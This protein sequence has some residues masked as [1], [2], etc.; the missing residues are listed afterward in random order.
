MK[1]PKAYKDCMCLTSNSKVSIKERPK[2]EDIKN[3]CNEIFTYAVESHSTVFSNSAIILN[4]E[5]V[6]GHISENKLKLR[7][8]ALNFLKKVSKH[9]KIII[10]INSQRIISTI[11]SLM[12]TKSILI[13]GIYYVEMGKNKELVY[14]NNIYKD[15]SISDPSISVIMISSLNLEIS[16]GDA[17]F[18]ASFRIKKKLNIS[19]CPIST[20]NIPITFLVPHILINNS[21]R[22]FEQLFTSFKLKEK[23]NRTG[24]DFQE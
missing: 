24:F 2:D 7:R 1:N 6:I 12:K 20:E 5:G 18:P 21:S 19:M 14:L 22:P 15:F 13:C 11:V 8:G 17:I 9:F 23:E 3:M 10:L 16:K 4:F